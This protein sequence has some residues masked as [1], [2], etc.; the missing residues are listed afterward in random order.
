MKWEILY[1]KIRSFNEENIDKNVYIWLLLYYN[2][3]IREDRKMKGKKIVSLLLLTLLIGCAMKTFTLK[4][5]AEE[6]YAGGNYLYGAPVQPVYGLKFYVDYSVISTYGSSV[7][8]SIFD[9]NGNYNGKVSAIVLYPASSSSYP[10]YFKIN[11]IALPPTI[12]GQTFFYDKTGK[13]FDAD[14]AMDQSTI[15]KAKISITNNK[16]EFNISNTYNSNWF[17]KTVRHEVGHVFL[18]KHP[19]SPYFQSIMHQGAPNGST[20]SSTISTDDRS[21]MALKWH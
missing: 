18:L 3:I 21:N 17:G 4:A 2:T 10:D 15:Y 11:T 8:S 16:N 12:K 6:Y 7:F 9:W 13:Q 1:R 19:L 5:Y 14:I 20:I